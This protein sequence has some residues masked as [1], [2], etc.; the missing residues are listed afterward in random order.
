METVYQE[1]ESMKRMNYGILSDIKSTLATCV[2]LDI[3]CAQKEE[4]WGI[5]FTFEGVCYL[6]DPLELINS[7]Y[8]DDK[9]WLVKNVKSDQAIVVEVRKES[10]CYSWRFCEGAI[11]DGYPIHFSFDEYVCKIRQSLELLHE[12]WCEGKPTAYDKGNNFSKELKFPTP[13][14]SVFY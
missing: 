11:G 2:K 1:S 4:V 3:C 5:W 7:V 10:H 13:F 6:V 9:F 14:I 12:V 8:V